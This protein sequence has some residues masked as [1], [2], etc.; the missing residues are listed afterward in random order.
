MTN[1]GLAG[2]RRRLKQGIPP[3]VNPDLQ[4]FQDASRRIRKENKI[5]RLQ[6]ASQDARLMARLIKA[7]QNTD[8][9]RM[10][11]SKPEDNNSS[12]ETEQK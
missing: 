7:K 10:D 2:L 6:Q 11:L 12:P 1:I 3:L 4:A 8:R 9:I 5:L